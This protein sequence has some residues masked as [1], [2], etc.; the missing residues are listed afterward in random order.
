MLA[1]PH[2][3]TT[4]SYKASEDKKRRTNTKKLVCT[5]CGSCSHVQFCLSVELTGLT[6]SNTEPAGND[7]SPETLSHVTFLLSK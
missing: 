2:N 7:V 5:H 6:V 1:S 3:I 4:D